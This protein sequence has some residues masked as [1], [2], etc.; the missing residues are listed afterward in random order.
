MKGAAYGLL[1]AIC[2][3]RDGP[4]SP[5]R[6]DR[7]ARAGI[8]TARAVASARI[9]R[10]APGGVP[11]QNAAATRP[12]APAFGKPIAIQGTPNAPPRRLGAF[13]GALIGAAHRPQAFCRTVNAHRQ[14]H[15]SPMSISSRL[16]H[17]EPFSYRRAGLPAFD[18]AM[19]LLVMDGE[20]GLCSGA[21]RRIAR[22]DR[23]DRIRIATSQST[24]GRGLLRHYGLDPD[25]P[26][27][28][29]MI[30]AG[31]ALRSLDAMICLFPRL[32]PG[33][34]PLRLLRVVPRRWRDAIYA[35]IARNRYRVFGRA[36]LCAMPDR[37]LQRRLIA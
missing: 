7:P 23:D 27:S 19:I 35:V 17:A 8:A 10:G 31:R 24:L 11:G 18:E 33:F 3:T 32:H 4:G 12:L 16:D 2:A 26:D 15:V 1:S 5:N 34:W 25:N 6:G 30:E 37:A 28:W 20:C 36:Q 14:G 22:L 13:P 21:A 9:E 29:L